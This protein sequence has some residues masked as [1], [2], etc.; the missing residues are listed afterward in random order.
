MRPAAGAEAQQG[1]QHRR[2]AGPKVDAHR[3]RAVGRRAG[4]DGHEVASH[5]NLPPAPG[6]AAPASGTRPGSV[7]W[8]WRWWGTVPPQADLDQ[9]VVVAPFGLAARVSASKFASTSGWSTSEPYTRTK[10]P[11]PMH[12]R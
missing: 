11:R 3:D 1:Q 9:D 5:V 7:T 6:V 10:Q 8:R 4:D 2:H 12:G